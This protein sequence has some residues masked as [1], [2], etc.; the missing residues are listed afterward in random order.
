MIVHQVLLHFYLLLNLDFNIF[1]RKVFGVHRRVLRGLV[2]LVAVVR[3]LIRGVILLSRA[4]KVII[5]AE[6]AVGLRALAIATC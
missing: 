2:S 5:V 3:I 1:D 6:P 4:S